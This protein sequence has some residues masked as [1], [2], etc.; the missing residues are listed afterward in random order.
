MKLKGVRELLSPSVRQRKNKNE[1]DCFARR[2]GDELDGDREKV[3]M[4]RQT[5]DR[6]LLVLTYHD[7]YVISYPTNCI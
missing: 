4:N 7:G 5:M 6:V 3:R 1:S 2:N